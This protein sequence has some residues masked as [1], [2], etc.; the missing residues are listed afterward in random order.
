ME[1]HDLVGLKEPGIKLIQALE[2]AFGKLYQPIHVIRMAK[3]ESQRIEIISNKICENILLPMKYEKDGLMID[4]QNMSELESRTIYRAFFQEIKKQQNIE[5]VIRKSYTELEKMTDVSSD[6]VDQDWIVRFFNSVEDIGEEHMQ[7][8]WA[9]ILAGEIRQPKSFSKRTL[10]VLK[11]LSKEEAQ[12]FEKICK[13]KLIDGILDSRDIFSEI[14]ITYNDILLLSECGLIGANSLVA[15]NELE[16]TK[17]EM[18]RFETFSI[19]ASGKRNTKLNYMIYP[20]TMAG[21]EIS[22]ILN[23]N[24][25]KVVSKV[26]LE[27]LK[28]QNSHLT[29]EIES[30]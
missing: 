12:L 8:I 6:P 25:D 27:E 10:E 13:G 22:S 17:D 18:A 23:I 9:K 1:F 21:V 5:S 11:H 16:S 14:K 26:M 4:T 2:G 24:V 20:L 30:N 19:F 15:S 3:A 29:I 28:R 7:E